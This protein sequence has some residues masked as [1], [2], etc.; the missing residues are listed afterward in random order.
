MRMIALAGEARLELHLRPMLAAEL[1]LE[2][3][4]Q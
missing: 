1:S 3:S 2:G 4:Y